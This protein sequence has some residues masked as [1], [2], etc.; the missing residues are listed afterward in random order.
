MLSDGP[1]GVRGERFDERDPSAVLP[2]PT[3]VAASWD[4]GLARRLG[5]L[6]AAEARRKGWTSS[7]A[8]P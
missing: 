2:S 6:L 4:P 5:G 1:A 7:S 3:A 8:R